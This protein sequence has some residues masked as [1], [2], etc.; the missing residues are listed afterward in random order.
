MDGNTLRRLI[1]TVLGVGVL[2]FAG[3]TACE[4]EGPAERTGEEI[5]EATEDIAEDVEDAADDLDDNR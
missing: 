1:G 2:S 3:L 4:Q 5:D